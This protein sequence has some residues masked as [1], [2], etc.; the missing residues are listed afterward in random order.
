MRSGDA[1]G[2]AQQPGAQPQPWNSWRKSCQARGCTPWHNTGHLTGPTQTPTAH[3]GKDLTWPMSCPPNTCLGH[4][5][6]SRGSVV[7]QLLSLGLSASPSHPLC[8]LLICPDV[9][10]PHQD[11]SCNGKGC[12]VQSCWDALPPYVHGAV[13]GFAGEVLVPTRFQGFRSKWKKNPDSS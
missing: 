5:L 11:Q 8:H 12:R 4:W 3:S 6:S 10:K 9:P 7:L 13:M 2:H 1:H